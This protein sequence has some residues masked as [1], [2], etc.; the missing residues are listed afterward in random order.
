MEQIHKCSVCDTETPYEITHT[1]N[2]V[3]ETATIKC[4]ECNKWEMRA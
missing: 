4:R 2:V 1:S 3:I